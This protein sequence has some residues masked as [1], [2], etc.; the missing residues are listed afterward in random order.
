MT[1]ILFSVLMIGCGTSSVIYI[2]GER[3]ENGLN[4]NSGHDSL[5]NFSD[6]EGGFV[7]ATGID[8]D[9]DGILAQTEVMYLNTLY[10]GTAGINGTNAEHAIDLII[11][12]C[13]DGRGIDEIVLITTNGVLSW[14]H[15][16]GLVLLGDGN[17][18]TNDRQRCKFSIVN[19]SFVE[20]D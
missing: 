19:G 20:V 5:I 8:L 16:I 4:G 15:N 6:I 3:G 13:G 1:L 18:T 17:H 14:Y 12:P 9:D 11:D 2:P 7:V 10:N